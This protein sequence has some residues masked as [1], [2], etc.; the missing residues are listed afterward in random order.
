MNTGLDKTFGMTFGEATSLLYAG[1][2]SF[3]I[4]QVGDDKFLK[5]KPN[6]FFLQSKDGKELISDYRIYL[7]R[8][9]EYEACESSLRG[10]FSR[11]ETIDD[12]EHLVERPTRNVRSLNIP[13]IRPTLPGLAADND[14]KTVT[15]YF[16]E[17]RL[18]RFLH[19]KL[20]ST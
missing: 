7:T 13:G 15:A 19:A 4:E 11:I 9:D 10:A 6:G 16:S 12:F 5:V 14:R 20:R 3:E 18:V 8:Y 2:L 1:E 17:D